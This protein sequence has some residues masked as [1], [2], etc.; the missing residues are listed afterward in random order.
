MICMNCLHGAT[1][2]VNSRPHKKQAQTWR[3]RHCAHCGVDFTTQ[4]KPV[5]NATVLVLNERTGVNTP[6]YQG[7]IIY[8]I[9]RCFAHDEEF[10]INNAPALSDTIVAALLPL[11]N[12]PLSTKAIT[13]ACYD[14]LFRFDKAAAAQYAL[15][16]KI[17]TTP[18]RRRKSA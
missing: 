10:G 4:E 9:I 5:F 8:S 2:V 18:K 11:N 7:K 15:I 1:S 6:F 3:R 16:H 13:T 12:K 17:T 14:T